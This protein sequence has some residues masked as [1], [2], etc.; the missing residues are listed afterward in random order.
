MIVFAP[1]PTRGSPKSIRVGRRAHGGHYARSRESVH[2]RPFFLP[3]GHHFLYRPITDPG[4]GPIYVASLD[5]AERKF[6]FNSD[7]SNVVYSQ[8]YLLFLRETTLM[9]QPF[10]AR[11][12]VLTGDAFPI[13]ERF[14]DSG[15]LSRPGSSQRR[16]MGCWCTRRE[17]RR[18]TQLVW[19][20]RTGKQTG[21]LGDPAYT[22]TWSSLLTGSGL[23]SAFQI[24]RGRGET[25]G[26]TTWH[27]DCE[28]VSLW[29]RTAQ[30]SIW[31]PDGSRIVF[32]SNRKGRYDLY[33]KASSGA[34][35]D[36]VLLEDNLDKYPTSWS[37]D[38]QF[39]LYPTGG[40]QTRAALFVLPV[41]GDRKPVPFLQTQFNET[42]VN[43]LPTA[44][45]SRI[46][47]TSLEETKFML[48]PFL[49]LVGSG[50]SRRPAVLPDGVMTVL[51]FSMSLPTTS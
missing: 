16:R 22:A 7:S 19:F 35:A 27:A 51:R 36:E 4:G 3:D 9:A 43:F 37:P 8:G 24:K 39:I 49:G 17:R 41:S 38:G 50:R 12:L 23:P 13:A 47:Q 34:G 46:F 20:D 31:S 30:T 2:R 44:N 6:L 33:Q 11:R 18:G 21:V 1:T 5:S 10:D 28:R 26:F 42:R 32:N 40:P 29:A 25:S 45:G 14:R 15:T 48:P